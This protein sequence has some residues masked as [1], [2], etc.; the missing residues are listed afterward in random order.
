MPGDRVEVTAKSGLIVRTVI[1]TVGGK[2]SDHLPVFVT[3]EDGEGHDWLDTRLFTI[4]RVEEQKE[5]T[6]A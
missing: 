2:S 5:L 6:K 4:T 1:R 3:N